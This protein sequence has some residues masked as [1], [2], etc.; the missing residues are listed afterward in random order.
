MTTL[1]TGEKLPEYDDGPAD[2]VDIDALHE[3][4]RLRFPNS[5]G[6]PEHLNDANRA[7]VER[8]HRLLIGQMVAALQAVGD[9]TLVKNGT[10]RL[11]RRDGADIERLAALLSRVAPLSL[12]ECGGNPVDTVVAI[13]KVE[14]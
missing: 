14:A 10:Y 5:W 12:V 13:T 9:A 6:F 8:G 7:V 4:L 1:P 2:G 3:W 11:M